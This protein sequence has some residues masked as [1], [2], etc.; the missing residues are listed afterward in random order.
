[1]TEVDVL[2]RNGASTDSNELWQMTSKD[3]K[4][5]NMRSCRKF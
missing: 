5:P 4:S 1:M 3:L 2:I